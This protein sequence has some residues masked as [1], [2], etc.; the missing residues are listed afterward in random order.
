MPSNRRI[1]SRELEQRLS[2]EQL[3]LSHKLE[4]YK[5]FSS[6][7]ASAVFDHGSI[8]IGTGSKYRAMEDQSR[9]DS[10]EMNTQMYVDYFEHDS[11]NKQAD[12][13]PAG[14]HLRDVIGHLGGAHVIVSDTSLINEHDFYVYCFSYEC[15]ESVAQSFKQDAD[16]VAKIS[17]IWSLAETLVECHHSLVGMQYCI[18]SVI[19]TERLRTKSGS[20]PH[21]FDAPFEKDPIFSPNKEGRVVFY[22]VNP[23]TNRPIVYRET[24]PIPAPF[25]HPSVRRFFSRYPMPI[26]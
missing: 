15:S 10:G 4:V 18:Y 25:E 23:A 5:S 7:F 14:S 9:K 21:P 20:N 26:A 8:V 3:N 17:N 19:Y 13:L 16:C 24:L 11:R 22:K 2:P 1:T 6:E 12:A